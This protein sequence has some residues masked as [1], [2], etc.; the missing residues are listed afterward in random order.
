[1]E[2]N[3]VAQLSRLRKLSAESV[4]NTNSFDPFKE[5]LHVERQVELEL[6]DLL[7]KIHTKQQKCLVLL[8]GSAGDGKSHLISYL[9]NSDPEGLLDDFEPY[10][11]ATESSEPTLTSIDTLAYKLQ[12]F[13][14]DNCEIADGKKMIVAVNLGTLNN[15]IDSE[16][17][18]KYSKLKKYVEENGIFSGYSQNI[19]YKEGSL[20]QHVSFS[21]YQVF[22]LSASGIETS[23]L[24]SLFEK[25]FYKSPENPFY[26][27]YQKCNMCPMGKRCPVK[28]NFEFLSVKERQKRVIERIIEI[29]IEDKAIV[30]TREV[31]N[32]LYDIMVH[33][34]FNPQGIGVGTSDVKY[35]F[36]YL[37][38]STP[39]LLN[40]YKDIS[41]ILNII[42]RHD[43]L[44]DRSNVSDD[45][46]TQFHSL[47]NIY[48][49]FSGATINTPYQV[50][51]N[52][53]D[54]SVLG[55]IKPELKKIIYRF[56]AR[57]RDFSDTKEV[58]KRQI[59]LQRF[60][61]CLYWQNSGNERKLGELY[62]ST[63]KAIMGWDGNFEEEEICIDDSNDQLWI[64][65]Q[66]QIKSVIN[67][68]AST[69][70]GDIQRFSL[71]LNL[72]F[73]K[74]NS[75]ANEIVTLNMD[76]ALYELVLNMK[77]GYRPTVQDRNRHA[78]FVSFIQRLIEFGNKTEKIML[79][80]KESGKQYKMIF[81]ETEFGYEFKVV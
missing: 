33:P 2:C 75:S 53:T 56:I 65:E 22:S 16:K 49:V 79:I 3:F 38:W 74:A 36:N 64:V 23:F 41:P 76:Y 70:T 57:I 55:G 60:I 11:D 12:A 6:R 50:L 69:M 8:C 28:H 31:L 20:F 37:N 46:V 30:S 44:K 1:M 81:E 15:F 34:E 29:V 9:K 18:R 26:F 51:N 47:D 73:Q 40:E 27:A 35:L 25:V 39:M 59:Q 52:L 10:N 45:A 63:R 42:G 54:V 71:N 13:N 66:L 62:K 48:D 61:D 5:Y 58:T 17:G 43:I 77:E 68:Q 80:P 7:R 24:D 21:D 78:D 14:D 32:L 67:K 4:E 19:G 72:K